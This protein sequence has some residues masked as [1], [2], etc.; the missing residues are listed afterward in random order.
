MPASSPEFDL[1]CW[2]VSDVLPLPSI[3][4]VNIIDLEKLFILAQEHRVVPRLLDKLER[5]P[6]PAIPATFKARL[7]FNRMMIERHVH[8]HLTQAKVITNLPDCSC[9]YFKGATAY[10]LT[11]DKKTMRPSGDIDL[12]AQDPDQLFQTMLKAGYEGQLKED[13][14]RGLSHEHSALTGFGVMVEIQRFN[15]IYY[16]QIVGQKKNFP[17]DWSTLC[18]INHINYADLSEFIQLSTISESQGLP[19]LSPTAAALILC[20]HISMNGVYLP[21]Q[22]MSTLGEIADL[23]LLIQHPQFSPHDFKRLIEK[24]NATQIVSLSLAMVRHF[25]GV[26]LLARVGIDPNID[27]CAP[28]DSHVSFGITFQE[29]L[30]PATIS[31]Y[32]KRLS[33]SSILGDGTWQTIPQKNILYR[34][35][36]GSQAMISIVL[37][38]TE[39]KMQIL[40][41]I[42]PEKNAEIYF[43]CFW[44]ASENRNTLNFKNGSPYFS[45]GRSILG[46]KDGTTFS[47]ESEAEISATKTD[48]GILCTIFARYDSEKFDNT[49]LIILQ[50]WT[51]NEK[52]ERN[53]TPVLIIPL[54]IIR[55]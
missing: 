10:A 17:H 1:L 20:C 53:S 29:T 12:F 26:D 50:Q 38:E 35:T 25:L 39:V 7:R 42:F 2:A 41:K 15:L 32:V 9:V 23:A 44:D 52:E 13:G 11:G 16:G 4:E 6:H 54:E 30:R 8:H 55:S 19:I 5:E 22:S 49:F 34:G 37:S 51:Y 46:F 21:M 14:F 3:A 36:L 40:W 33:Y 18:G 45:E 47:W 27:L 31:E 48:E 28:A 43:L 24:H